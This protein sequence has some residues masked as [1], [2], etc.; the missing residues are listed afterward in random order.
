[1]KRS[2]SGQ[3]PRRASACRGIEL[4][5]LGE[6]HGGD[7][8]AAHRQAGMAGIGLLDRVHGQGADGVRHVGSLL[9]ADQS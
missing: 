9:A 2:R 6:Q 5:D 4:H 1:M 7:V 8:G 3:W